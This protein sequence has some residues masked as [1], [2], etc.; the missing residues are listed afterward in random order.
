M[1]NKNRT[2]EDKITTLDDRDGVEFFMF[3]PNDK[4][5]DTLQSALEISRLNK[6]RDGGAQ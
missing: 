2:I 3:E 5:L 1:E 6:E 4:A